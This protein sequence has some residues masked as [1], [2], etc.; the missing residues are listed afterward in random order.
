VNTRFGPPLTDSPIRELTLL[1]H[2]GLVHDY[3][4][5]LM[6]LSCCNPSIME[7]QQVQLFI[8]GL[9]APLWTG[10][11]TSLNDVVMYARAYKQR[12]LQPVPTQS[13]ASQPPSHMFSKPPAPTTTPSTAS[14][15]IGSSAPV[16]GKATATTMRLSS[17]DI[18]QRHREGKCFHYD[19]FFT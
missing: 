15:P 13:S 14:T 19:D 1:R 10:V 2:D 17:P 12:A 8:I 5:R 16:T 9:G 6:V 7:A 11:A 18:A 4:K 3:A